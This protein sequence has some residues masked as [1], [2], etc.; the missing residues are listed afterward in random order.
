MAKK[1]SEADAEVDHRGGVAVAVVAFIGF[2][3]WKRKNA[4]PEGIASGNGRH[5]GEA[6]RRRP[7][8]SRCGSRRSSST[9]ARW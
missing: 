9:R 2:R 3:Y 6:R 8:R 1:I 4:L 5:R 7:P